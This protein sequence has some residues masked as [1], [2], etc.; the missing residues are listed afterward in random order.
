M[1]SWGD[2]KQWKSAELNGVIDGVLKERRTSVEA[3]EHIGRVDVSSDWKGAGAEAAQKSLGKLKDGSMKHLGFVGDLLMASQEAFEGVGEVE[4]GVKEAQSFAESAQL[5]IQD[6][7]SVYDMKPRKSQ[8]C[9]APDNSG[10]AVMKPSP[11]EQARQREEEQ[12][13]ANERARLLQECKDK[14][15]NLCRKAQEVDDTYRRKLDEISNGKVSN[16]ENFD[17]PTPGLPDLPKDTND[18][19]KNAQWWY[20]LTD[21]ERKAIKDKAVEDIKA[22]RG[23][24][25][26]A[27]GN[28]NGVDGATR[29]EINRVR[30]ER[31][32]KQLHDELDDIVRPGPGK[33]KLTIGGT[34]YYLKFG[35]DFNS[36]M[37][38]VQ[39]VQKKVREID[40]VVNA[41]HGDKN[42]SLYLYEPATG[43]TGHEA[44]HAAYV[45]GDIDK[46]DHVSTF[47]PGME[48][49]V[50]DSGGN[51]DRMND[52]KNR[53]EAEGA[54]SVATISWVGYDA[55]PDPQKTGDFSVTNTGDAEIG[56]GSLAKH[57]EGIKDMRDASHH[58][59]HQSVLGHSYGSTTSSYA[60]KQVRPGVVDDYAVF[61]SPGVAG[62]AEDMHVPDG[63]AYA[64]TYNNIDDNNK[65]DAVSSKDS[66]ISGKLSA[67][68]PYDSD[69]GFKI[70]DPGPSG[71][72]GSGL[73]NGGWAA[74][75]NYL[76]NG[77]TAQQHLAK[78]SAGKAA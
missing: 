31:D 75:S 4:Q 13:E 34:D 59:V 44:T 70:M 51:I 52:L 48:T 15:Q 20:A 30:A 66:F 7:G 21:N 17:D 78:I 19:K 65:G 55:P 33:F 61:G 47:V 50:A 22:G 8:V 25:Y 18:P 10:H 12:Q 72:S 64:M 35:E 37:T 2:I 5:E 24:K 57:L 38:R 42:V 63:H 76:N 3:H 58:P 16:Q 29:N 14:V 69:S 28:M 46:A 68:S 26:E 27:L 41:I 32:Q 43:E 6:D 9:E 23:S 73:G 71:D 54:G 1:V 60:M 49:T 40:G 56:G 11:K 45:S 74:H 67:K 53:A 62:K 39:E 36:Y 77:T